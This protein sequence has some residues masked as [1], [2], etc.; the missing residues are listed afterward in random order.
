MLQG[1]VIPATPWHAGHGLIAGSD[2]V[3]FHAEAVR[4]AEDIERIG[5]RAWQFRP[6]GQAPV[7]IAAAVYAVS[8]IHEP[9][10]LLPLNGILYGLAAAVLFNMAF[11]LSGNRR[12]AFGVVLP[13]LVFPST[14]MI[15]GQIHK[16][17]WILPGCLLILSFW[18]DLGRT[19]VIDRSVVWLLAKVLAGALLVWI[20]RPYA[21]KILLL[22][23][24]TAAIILLAARVRE[25]SLQFAWLSML[26]SGLVIQLIVIQ[27]PNPIAD[28]PQTVPVQAEPVAVQP[29]CVTWKQS[30]PVP[31][32]DGQLAALA[33]LREG[34]RTGYPEAGSNI[35]TEVTFTNVT[36]IFNY[37]PRAL[38]ISLFAPF[39]DS[40]LSVAQSPGGGFMRLIACAEMLVLYGALIGWLWLPWFSRHDRGVLLAVLGFS[41]TAALIYALVICNVGTLYRMRYPVMFVWIGLGLIGWQRHYSMR[42]AENGLSFR[43]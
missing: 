12:S 15:W 11:T 21:N 8:G 27:P 23:S 29:T 18:I 19:K 1:V 41:M 24:M 30:P 17:V 43:E 7:G 9:W 28:Q 4:L 13:L 37:L 5:W 10:A 22:A 34:F 3:S 14:A 32:I 40:W 35:D 25:K 20:V 31:L 16:D 36:D 6:Q 26:L 33:C 39:P 42:N 38:Q 2:W